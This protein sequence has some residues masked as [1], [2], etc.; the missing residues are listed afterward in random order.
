M[1]DRPVGERAAVH[2]LDMAEHGGL[3]TGI[4]H[5]PFL[6]ALDLPDLHGQLRSPAE[7]I[8]ELFVQA[9]NAPA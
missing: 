4:V 5:R 2:A 6:P 1:L 9:V 8:E 3:A 7:E